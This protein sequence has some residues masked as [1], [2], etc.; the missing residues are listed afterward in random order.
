MSCIGA[1]I[2]VAVEATPKIE[3]VPQP[4][5]PRVQQPCWWCSG[6]SKPRLMMAFAGPLVGPFDS[7][8]GRE[9]TEAWN[10]WNLSSSDRLRCGY[11]FAS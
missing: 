1:H 10:D 3:W 6:L 7:R 9:R 2:N 4:A 11:P 5:A 8:R